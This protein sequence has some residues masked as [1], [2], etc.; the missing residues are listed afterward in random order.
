MSTAVHRLWR[1]RK[2]YQTID[3]ELQDA[4]AG[5]TELQFR[6]NGTP[7]YSRRCSTREE[8]VAAAEERRVELEREGWMSHW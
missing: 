7:M 3:A 8:A 2:L 6:L 1:L 5:T 4:G